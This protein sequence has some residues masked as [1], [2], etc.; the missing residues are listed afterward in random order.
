MLLVRSHVFVATYFFHG[1]LYTDILHFLD[2]VDAFGHVSARNPDNASQFI[3]YGIS[4][5]FRDGIFMRPSTQDLCYSPR[6]G[7]IPSP[8][9]VIHFYKYTACCQPTLHPDM[10]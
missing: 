9:H 8:S 1:V 2:V 6:F 3:M 4:P 10:K 5:G 7:H